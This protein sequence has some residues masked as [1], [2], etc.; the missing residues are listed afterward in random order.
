MTSLRDTI[1]R[2]W[3]TGRFLVL[4]LA[5]LLDRLEAP[6]TAD[7]PAEREDARIDLL[8]RALAELASPQAAAGRVERVLM[9][10]SELS[11]PASA[12]RAVANLEIVHRTTLQLRS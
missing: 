3:L 8:H 7:E 2:E 1:D 10:Y 12:P 9:L 11:A 5:A 4:E 6:A